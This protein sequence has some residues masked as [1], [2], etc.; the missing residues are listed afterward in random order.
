MPATI[1][2]AAQLNKIG[3]GVTS[4]VSTGIDIAS[5]FVKPSNKAGNITSS[6]LG[7]AATAAGIAS[8]I[9]AASA[10]LNAVPIAG[11]FASAG[12]ALAG[13]LTKI[14]VGRRQKKKAK[15][16]EKEEARIDTASDAIQ[17]SAQSDSAGGIGLPSNQ[18]VGKTAPVNPPTTTSYA[19]WGGGTAPTTQPTQKALSGA[20]GI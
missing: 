1:Q 15:R 16:R 14:F 13:L 20:M 9:F 17:G 19:S 3:G 18:P 2:G 11:Q 4:G 12:L 5:G 8:S 10:G 7:G 6:T